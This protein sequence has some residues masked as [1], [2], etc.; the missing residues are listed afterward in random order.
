[1]PIKRIILKV[2][3]DLYL[4]ASFKCYW[5]CR[6]IMTQLTGKRS[7]PQIFFNERLVGG[8]DDFQKLVNTLVYTSLQYE[9][10][11]MALV[12]L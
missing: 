4:Q 9:E 5:Y 12:I 10:W 6:E 8:N 3:S 7:V 11:A 2:L 1:M